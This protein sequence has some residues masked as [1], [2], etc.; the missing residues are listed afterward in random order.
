MLPSFSIQKYAP[1]FGVLEKTW[2]GIAGGT[3]YFM[4][5][6]IVPDKRFWIL[7]EATFYCLDSTVGAEI[8]IM[9]IGS[10]HLDNPLVFDILSI[11]LA[12][13]GVSITPNDA[14]ATAGNPERI[15]TRGGPWILAPGQFLRVFHQDVSLAGSNAALKMAVAE[16]ELCP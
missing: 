1:S 10:R 3:A 16:M 13:F 6:Q 9:P 2:L 15:T 14:R 11:N 8:M 5:S 4:D 7:Q 12:D